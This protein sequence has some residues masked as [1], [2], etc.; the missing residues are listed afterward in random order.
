MRSEI[1]IIMPTYNQ[2][3]FIGEAMDSVL[4]QDGGRTLNL[5][6][7]N[8][9]CT[10]YTAEFVRSYEPED[11]KHRVW[12]LPPRDEGNVGTH[13][14]INRGH[15]FALDYLNPKLMTWVSSDNIMYP[16][17]LDSQIPK[18]EEGYAYV[19]ANFHI[20][21]GSM[22]EGKWETGDFEPK[23]H[24]IGAIAK[25]SHL[26]AH[27]W[28]PAH[29]YTTALWR[30][31]GLHRPGPAHDLDWWLRAEEASKCNGYKVE[32]PLCTWRK[33]EDNMTAKTRGRDL[34]AD[35]S[36]ALS[37]AKKRRANK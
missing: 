27:T 17:W 3:D 18:I 10:D 9:G 35:T 36:Q 23:V 19:N 12:L 33:H 31:V 30:K 16:H 11:R 32:E 1:A 26:A 24:N 4:R 20:E 34:K 15:T 22:V 7:V 2:V 5:V 37:D 8:D 28:G 25:P 13:D 6:V 21:A 29:L 14:A